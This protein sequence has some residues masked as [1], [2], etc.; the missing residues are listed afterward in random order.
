[1]YSWD[2][3][4]LCS[5]LTLEDVQSYYYYGL[6]VMDGL[7]VL[8]SCN[9]DGKKSVFLFLQPMFQTLCLYSCFRPRFPFQYTGKWIKE[10]T[11][12][13]FCLTIQPNSRNDWCHPK[14]MAHFLFTYEVFWSTLSLV[15]MLWKQC[16]P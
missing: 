4:L 5:T 6:E 12:L 10:K 14:K 9:F 1:M 2:L 11:N 13:K 8:S 3:W 16:L 7:C 15:G